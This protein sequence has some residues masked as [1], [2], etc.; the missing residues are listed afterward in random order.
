MTIF[1][2]IEVERYV[3]GYKEVVDLKDF[4][5]RMLAMRACVRARKREGRKGETDKRKREERERERKCND[6]KGE[7][8]NRLNSTVVED[9]RRVRVLVHRRQPFK[10]QLGRVCHDR[11]VLG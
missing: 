7:F 6:A 9:G 11:W 4:C 2:R 5:Q 1:E 10:A 3:E 8:K